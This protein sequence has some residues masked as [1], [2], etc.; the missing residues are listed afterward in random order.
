MNNINNNTSVHHIHTCIHPRTRVY[1]R[2]GA[3][4]RFCGI[5]KPTLSPNSFDCSIDS[6]R[7]NGS[8]VNQATSSPILASVA[9]VCVPSP[10]RPSSNNDATRGQYVATE[11]VRRSVAKRV[12]STI[13]IQYDFDTVRFCGIGTSGPKL[14]GDACGNNPQPRDSFFVLSEIQ[15]SEK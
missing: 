1:E 15:R 7:A 10:S 6:Y 5:A 14:E 8:G 11:R 12:S 13:S 2:G 4:L 9:R 3:I